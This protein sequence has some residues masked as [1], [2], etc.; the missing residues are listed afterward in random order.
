MRKIFK[1]VGLVVLLT[2]SVAM[3][4]GCYRSPGD[5]TWHTPHEYK[6]KQDPLT[7]KLQAEG[8]DRRLAERFRSVQ[9]DR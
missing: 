3:A 2:C 1:R 5:T 7:G 4:A 6:G 8:F 9:T